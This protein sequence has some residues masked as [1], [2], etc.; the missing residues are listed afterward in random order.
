MI[1]LTLAACGRPAEVLLIEDN[2]GDVMLTREA[3]RGAK[4]A[5]NLAVAADGEVGLAMLRREGAYLNQPVPDLILLDLNLPRI[6]GRE[7]LQAIK[8]DPNLQRIPVIVLTSSK[9]E[10]DILKTYE[11]GA[12]AYVVKPVTFDR[13]QEIV[14]S[15]ESFW[16][17][18]VV[19]ASPNRSRSASIGAVWGDRVPFKYPLRALA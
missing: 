13:M 9:A 6:D 7:V 19:L 12:N 10:I 18:V 2:G 3:F 5:N 8:S 16:F 14:A 17:S 15:I 11:I 1:D 4:L